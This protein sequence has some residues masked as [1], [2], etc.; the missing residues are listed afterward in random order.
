MKHDMKTNPIAA[1]LSTLPETPP[2]PHKEP[3]RRPK[4]VISVLII[5]IYAFLSDRESV[6]WCQRAFLNFFQK[7]KKWPQAEIGGQSKGQ[8]KTRDCLFTVIYAVSLRCS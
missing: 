8:K 5:I 1:Q 2:T 7:W 6:C 3:M 4:I